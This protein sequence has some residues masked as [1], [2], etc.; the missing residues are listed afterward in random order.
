MSP[1]CEVR[2]QEHSPVVSHGS[3]YH[4]VEHPLLTLRVCI[5]RKFK[6]GAES[7]L[8]PRHSEVG[9]KQ[10][11][12][13]LIHYASCQPLLFFLYLFILQNALYNHLV[14]RT[15]GSTVSYFCVI[16][17]WLWTTAAQLQTSESLLPPSPCPVRES[18]IGTNN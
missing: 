9:C 4:L 11:K 18:R 8:Q 12:W 7:Q 10:P 15:C 5:R 1:G 13:R 6:K 2:K 17:P 3:R 14:F 16:G